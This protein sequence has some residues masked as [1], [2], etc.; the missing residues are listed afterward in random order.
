MV[1][2]AVKPMVVDSVD[3]KKL[4]KDDVKKAVVEELGFD[5]ANNIVSEADKE[6]FDEQLAEISKDDGN[7]KFDLDEA[8][9]TYDP[10][11]PRYKISVEA[12]E[13]FNLMRMVM[14]EDFE[15]NTPKAH[16]FMVDMLLGNIT[17]PMM[18]PY[19]E[20]ICKTIEIDVLR[21]S[22]MASRGIAK[23][24]VVITF[25]G[26]YSA[27]KG[28]LPNDLGRIYFYLVV[29]ASSK[30]G[31]RVNAKAVQS[32]CVE[33]KFLEDIFESMRFTETE[34]EF[35][36]RGSGSSKSRTFLMRYQGI[37]TAIRG[38]RD[39][40]GRRPDAII[41]D[42]TILN[43]AAAYS[44]TQQETLNEAIH[45]DSINALKGGGRARIIMTFTPFSYGDV[46]TRTV[47][48]KSF[49]PIVIP[50]A[51]FFEVGAGTN[52]I[53]STWVAM[54]PQKSIKAQQLQAIRSKTLNLFLQE[55]ML[56]LTSSS[57]RLIPDE[58]FQYCDMK[59]I[60]DNMQNYTMLITTDYTTTSGEK[61]DYS[62]RAT[63]AISSDDD[64]FLLDVSL[65]KMTMRAQYTDTLDQA[66]E[67]KRRGSYVQLGIEIDGNQQA[68]VYS[69]EELMRKRGTYHAFA[70][71]KGAPDTR[72]G[73]LSRASGN[74]KHE[75]FRII[76]PQFLQKK[77]WLP[78]HLKDTPD[79]IELVEQLKGATHKEF[80]KSDDGPDLFS[81]LN[82]IQYSKPTQASKYR[83]N[84]N[85]RDSNSFWEDEED[86]SVDAGAGYS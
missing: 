61:S 72:K 1:H 28:K 12:I 7:D 39:N 42:D 53:R 41:G 81:M 4:N 46:N 74:A 29:T 50:I 6:W 73:I 38:I 52:S 55:R 11:F 30:G 63:F 20:E 65:R 56:Q 25:F 8:L 17:D 34:S 82:Q 60:R 62:G 3:F 54:H 66:D 27:I 71:Q 21:L 36:R 5:I 2:E 44:K 14:G 47:V 77:V 51:A 67:I 84:S 59:P 24:T 13:F 31:A 48:E 70:K 76:S 19:S 16:Y 68:H 78:E 64:W 23:S 40:H 33:S 57:D 49:T 9:R 10:D 69:L 79:M 58:C 37:N 26:V 83:M 85:N 15:F 80:T 22:F 32:M 35:V 86:T 45:S 43:T 75:R 18:F